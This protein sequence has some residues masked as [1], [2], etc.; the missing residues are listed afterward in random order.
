MKLV[1]RFFFVHFIK[2]R[3]TNL[4]GYSHNDLIYLKQEKY[5]DYFS[6]TN[7]VRVANIVSVTQILQAVR[8]V[9][10]LQW[11]NV[12]LEVKLYTVYCQFY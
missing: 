6:H 8:K 10:L 12:Y 5:V 9:W 3:K 4:R 2:N 7:M 11:I 1:H